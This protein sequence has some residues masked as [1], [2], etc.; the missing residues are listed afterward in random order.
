MSCSLATAET[1]ER[2]RGTWS[3]EAQPGMEDK[4]N[5]QGG[6]ITCWIHTEMT[7]NITGLGLRGQMGSP[8]GKWWEMVQ[9][10]KSYKG[11]SKSL[12]WEG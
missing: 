7:H 8:H 3:E 2:L 1:Q 11:Q 5:M 6:G 4:W 12:G 10:E 9:R